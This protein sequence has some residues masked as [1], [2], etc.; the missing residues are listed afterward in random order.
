MSKVG[1]NSVADGGEPKEPFE[2]ELP[3]FAEDLA[4]NVKAGFDS[5]CQLIVQSH[6]ALAAQIA[7]L[8]TRIDALGDAPAVAPAPPPPVAQ[9]QSVGVQ[10][11]PR[12]EE[13]RVGKEC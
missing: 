11:R 4:T 13:R 7:K 12:S 8:S 5:T 3:N 2:L 10:Q 9:P 1:D 6:A